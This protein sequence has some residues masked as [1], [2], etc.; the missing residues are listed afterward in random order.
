MQQSH[1]PS[2]LMQDRALFYSRLH[3]VFPQ[4]YWPLCRSSQSSL[5]QLKL[6]RRTE[7]IQENRTEQGLL[8]TLCIG[9]APERKASRTSDSQKTALWLQKWHVSAFQ[10]FKKV[11]DT[12]CSTLLIWNQPRSVWNGDWQRTKISSTILLIKDMCTCWPYRES[13]CT[14]PY[15]K[16]C[17][18]PCSWDSAIAHWLK[19]AYQQ[20]KAHSCS[21]IFEEESKSLFIQLYNYWPTLNLIFLSNLID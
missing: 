3:L 5:V 19:D 8:C 13:R 7:D 21:A 17:F 20:N 18:L 4:S 1:T 15:G 16:S 14:W 6:Q 10:P 11:A 9:L 12:E 2:K